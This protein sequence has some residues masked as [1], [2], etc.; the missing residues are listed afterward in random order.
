METNDFDY[1][2][3]ESDNSFTSPLLNVDND[4]DTKGI[5]FLYREQKVPDDTVV[6]LS[7]GTPVP[8]KPAMVDYLWLRGREVFSKKV[9]DVLKNHNFKGLQLVPAIIT[10]RKGEVYK[11][12]WI[13][14]VY[15]EYALLDPE[16]SERKGSINDFGCW[17]MVKKMVLNKELV[18]KMPLEDRL[19][20]TCRENPAYVLYHKTLVDLIM[21]VN[22]E[23]IVFIPIDKWYNGISYA[24]IHE[25]LGE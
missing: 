22:P 2:I 17:G 21:S 15:Q 1:Y 13:L 4:V 5:N 10:S 11:D 9:Y 24:L 6:Y 23:G 18:L 8:R 19:A 7:F 16:K 14:N 25:S 12:Y 3:A 20:F